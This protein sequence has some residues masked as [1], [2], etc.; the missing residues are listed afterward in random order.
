MV[1]IGV[2]VRVRVRVRLSVRVRLRVRV[3]GIKQRPST[4][5]AE[6]VNS[7]QEITG[8]SYSIVSGYW[9]RPSGWNVFNIF[10]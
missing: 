5:N 7:T 10:M 6:T 8:K 2:R 1:G 9:L 3:R 4:K